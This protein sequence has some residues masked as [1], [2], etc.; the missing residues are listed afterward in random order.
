VARSN[1][2]AATPAARDLT[3]LRAILARTARLRAAKGWQTYRASFDWYNLTFQVTTTQGVGLRRRGCDMAV[4]EWLIIYTI[5]PLLPIA[6]FYFG[7]WMIRGTIAWV[8]PIRMVR[9]A[10]TQRRLRLSPSKTSLK[11]NRLALNGCMA[12]SHV[13]CF[14]FSYM[15]FR[16]IRPYILH[17]TRQLEAKSMYVSR[18]PQSRVV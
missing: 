15:P 6:F 8:P 18:F 2:H 11:S 5:L 7:I 9:Y 4:I 13:G 16:F 12:W 17:G 14:P 10:S 1:R 3:I